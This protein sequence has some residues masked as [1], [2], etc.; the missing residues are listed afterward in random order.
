[1]MGQ[2][3]REMRFTGKYLPQLLDPSLALFYGCKYLMHQKKR[4]DGSW[5]QALAAYNGG[6][7]GHP[8]NRTAPYRNQ[9][10]VD[11]IIERARG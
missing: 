6:L 3:A 8:D 4:G 10:Y 1:M 11:E 9:F 2:T 5:A 7:G